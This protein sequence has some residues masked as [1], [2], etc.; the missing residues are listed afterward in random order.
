MVGVDFSELS[1]RAAQRATELA[2]F[3][4][5]KLV[6]LHVIEHFPEHLPHYQ[7]SGE[8]KGMDPEEYIRDR[9]AQDLDRMCDKLDCKDAE[10]AV[11]ITKHSAKSDLLDFAEE[12]HV[13]LIV[14]GS[15]GRGRLEEF[16][17]GSTATGVVRSAKCDVFTVRWT[18]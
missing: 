17:A 9:A 18:G 16:L 13:D 15:Q 6:F 11:R 7:M 2:G 1:E 8:G 4:G 5:A 14:L 3:Y 10:K 12:N